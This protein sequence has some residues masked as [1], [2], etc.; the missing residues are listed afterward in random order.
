MGDPSNSKKDMPGPENLAGKTN[1]VAHV[2][3]NAKK[4]KK[5]KN[6]III[7]NQTGSVCDTYFCG[8]TRKCVD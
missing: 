5:K 4:K 6:G 2:V 1:Q 7:T 8:E 3:V